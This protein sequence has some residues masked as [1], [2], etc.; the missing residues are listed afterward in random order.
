MGHHALA[1]EMDRFT[2]RVVAQRRAKAMIDQADEFLLGWLP[3]IM[4]EEGEPMR[5]FTGHVEGGE[6]HLA[7]ICHLLN[8][9]E[10]IAVI[11]PGERIFGETIRGEEKLVAV[12]G[13]VPDGV[14]VVRWRRFA[15]VRSRG[16]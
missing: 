6:E 4:L 1:T 12:L 2:E 5:R 8:T 15:G 14:N 11:Q 9:K 13:G 7:R 16:G 3:L 10:L